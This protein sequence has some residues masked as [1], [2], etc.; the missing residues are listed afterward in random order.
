MKVLLVRTPRYYW[1]YMSEGDNYLLPQAL[2]CLAAVLRE[3]DVEVKPVDCMPMKIGWKSL[4]EIVERERP[5]VIGAGDSE[6]LFCN[7]AAKFFRM[8]KEV[9][10]E[11]FTVAGGAHFSNL[12]DYCLQNYPVDAIVKWEG[13][14]TLLDLVRELEKPH[15]D[16][17]AVK[18]IAYRSNG[19][20]RH[21]EPRPL[22]HDLDDLPM[23]AYD[24]MPM[25][26]YG[27]SRFL[28]SPG[29]T[30]IHH[31]RGCT[32]RCNFCVLWKQM[33]RTVVRDDGEEILPTWRTKSPE[34]TVEEVELLR[35]KYKRRF[36]VWVDDTFN[37]SP[38]WNDAFAREMRERDLDVEWFANMRADYIL[39]DEQK[40][41]FKNL[42]RAGL[43]H[44][45]IGVE[46]A[47][48]SELAYLDKHGYGRDVAKRTFGMLKEK[49]PEVFRQ[50]TLIVGLA[51]ETPESLRRLMDLVHELDPDYPSFHPIMPVPGTALWEQA[52]SK[53]LVRDPY[54]WEQYDWLTPVMGT[55]AMTKEEIEDAIVD[56][57]LEYTK[58][59]W[60]LRGLLSRHRHRRHMYAWWLVMALRMTW[61]A[62]R[63][64][65]GPLRRMPDGY[66]FYRL[67]RPEW[68]DT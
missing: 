66:I 43:R 57:N 47:E 62:L 10:P 24:L 65:T 41:I 51:H 23:P 3:N 14:H 36:L 33:G 39:R 50:V 46:R 21:T 49:Y 13:E 38:K 26:A 61:A 9:D 52:V 56:M 5:D 25:A 18:G 40:G 59:P 45:L 42:V 32:D 60:L 15:P 35:T 31:S 4:R 16:L 30:T 67:V 28:Y 22:V 68:Y 11:I 8:V 63:E 37:V 7:E 58:I 55:E 53:G 12:A 27:K 20:V 34:R 17:S 29:G 6:T 64:R 44:V 48:D 1:P 19:A 2:P 54:D